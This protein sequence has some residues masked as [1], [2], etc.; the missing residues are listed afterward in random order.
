MSRP[1]TVSALCSLVMTALVLAI[2]P[3]TVLS[4]PA[5]AAVPSK[6]RWLADVHHAMAGSRAY[7]HR[8]VAHGGSR[9]AVNL[10]IDNTSLASHYDYGRRVPD[11]LRFARYARAR[12]VV[13]LFN[14]G[15]I[16]GDGRLI[17]AKHELMRAGYAVGEVCGR[18]SSA[19]GLAQGKRRCRRHFVAEGY[20]I[21]ANVGNRSTDFA[22]GNYRRAFRLPNYHNQLA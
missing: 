6:S 11:V 12:G 9:L 7:V 10:D 15:R 2:L 8:T 14:T 22:G 21:I 17:H 13:L 18:T 16:R 4:S 5:E 20:T 3:A 19:E 1:M